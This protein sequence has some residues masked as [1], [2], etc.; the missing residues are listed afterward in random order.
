MPFI[1]D[2]NRKALRLHYV[3]RRAP[4][5]ICQRLALRFIEWDDFLLS[6]QN[7]VKNRLRM[8]LNGSM[9]A[10]RPLMPLS[11]DDIRASTARLPMAKAA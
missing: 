3:D 10:Q 1:P 6:L 9:V 11:S 4:R 7:I 5:Q 8:E 2:K